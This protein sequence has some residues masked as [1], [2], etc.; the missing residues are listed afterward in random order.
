MLEKE[1][2]LALKLARSAGKT[3]L[4]HY[5]HDIIAEEKLGVDNYYEPVTETDRAASRIIVDGLAASFPVD[6]ILSEEEFDDP[7]HRLSKQ[8][9]WIIDPI[10]GTAGYVEKNG[11]FAVQIG[12]ADN[13]VP[14]LGVVYIPVPDLMYY[15]VKGS[16]AFV[17][18]Q[19][20]ETERLLVSD[21]SDYSEV[22]LAVSRHHRSSK[23][24][25]ISSELGIRTE[26]RRG[27]VGL[28]I[29]LIAEQICDMYIHLS[30]RSKIWDTCGP[31]VIVEEAGGRLTDLFGRPIRYDL[32]N[33]QNH[34]GI[35]A[36]N[37]NLHDRTVRRLAP[38]L[39]NF[40]R[41]PVEI[42]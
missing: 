6:A 31:Q 19:S 17:I 33:L 21:T 16:G 41:M 22:R 11:D 15:A 4:D 2:D 1:L 10:D 24:S 3:I 34:N 18:K 38:L 23:T 40:G 12:L 20:A 35:L 29:G 30:P 36:S 27:S 37:L 25:R 13:G 14:I 32:E 39:A 9:V 26:V 42:R 5:K 7:T 8:R 28:K